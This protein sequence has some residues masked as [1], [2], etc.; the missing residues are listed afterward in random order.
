M[1]DGGIVVCGGL[2][3]TDGLAADVADRLG[4]GQ[5]L[6]ARRTLDVQHPAV[7]EQRGLARPHFLAAFPA[8]VVHGSGDCTTI[9]SRAGEEAR[10]VA[11]PPPG[12]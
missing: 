8:D 11:A 6:A 4:A 5:W 3:R 9:G 12:V 1:H 7:A 2:P 10:S